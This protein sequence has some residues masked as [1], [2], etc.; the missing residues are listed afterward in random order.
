MVLG[1]TLLVL[2][3]LVIVGAVTFIN[4]SRTLENIS[5]VQTVQ[6]AESLSSVVQIAIERELKS[7]VAVANDPF[8]IQAV[9]QNKFDDIYEKLADLF[10]KLGVDY[11]GLAVIDGNGIVRVEGVD[12]KRVGISVA[13]RDYVRLAR[14]GRTG[15]GPVSLSKATGKPVFGLCAPIMSKDGRFM[16]GVLGVVKADFLVRCI[17]S[18]KLGKTGY[19]F[20]LDRNGMV[21]AHP[22]TSYIMTVDITKEEGGLKEAATN[23]I[24]QET[25]TA[26]YTY[27]G[28]KKVVGYA[29][30]KLTGWSIAVTQHKEEIMALAYTN[31]NLLLA[32][33]GFFLLLTVLAVFFFS[34]SISSPVQKSLTTLNQ[35]IEQ[36]TEAIIIIG[37]DRKVQFAN[38][39]ITRIIDRPVDELIGES[40]HLENTNMINSEEIWEILEK[41]QTWNG[42][43][44]G[45]KKDS[46][47]F[48]MDMTITPV[49]SEAGKINCFLAIGKDI[50]RELMIDAQ[51]RQ[52][53]KM[54]AIGTLA[55]GIAHDFNNILAA[56]MGYTELTIGKLKQPELQHYLEQILRAGER[57]RNLVTQILAFSLKGDKEVKPADISLLIRENLKLLR[58][59]IPSTI[60]I[61]SDIEPEVAKVLADP[62]QLHQVVMN[63]CTNAAHAMREKGGTLEVGLSNAEITPEML[64]LLPD[65]KPGPYVKLRV[66]DTGTGIA[67]DIMGKIFDPFF[68]T[69]ERGKGT[70]L[71]LSVVYGIVK[72]YGGAVAVQ[73]EL[74]KGSTFSTY[75]PAIE[76]SGELTGEPSGPIPGGSERIIFID[77]EDTLAEMGRDMLEG[78]GYEVIAETS[79]AGALEIFRAQP[80]RFDLVITDMTMPGMTGKELATEL[81]KIRPD[82]PII[83]CT[84]FSEIITEEEAGVMGIREFAMKPLDLRSIAELIR[85]ALEKKES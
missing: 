25:G 65:L 22:D 2:L 77:D 10:K 69:K 13:E 43:V 50:T 27:Q 5:K 49:R 12:K 82:I 34:R 54:E 32:V 19:A 85:K 74:G 39:A 46:S 14:E 60:E 83:L 61:R 48:S 17:S 78:L 63:L 30:L 4:S 68:T 9:F 38:P 58:A 52:S 31:R 1:G 84:G 37:L 15:I 81:L 55:G 51:L 35:A 66:D 33:C 42:C 18:L 71:G 80:D 59:T 23:M 57:A 16:G 20:M 11:E 62:T 70:G 53:Q 75:L 3:P 6:I 47:T 79:S 76:R 29:P 36:A 7:L 44:T 26:E 45:A 24:R 56:I 40:P 8:V 41:G 67:P 28:V 72:E 73:S 64:P 21:I